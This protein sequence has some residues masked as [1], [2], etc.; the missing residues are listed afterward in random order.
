MKRRDFL[1]ASVVGGAAVATVSTKARRASAIP[2]F[3]DV[4]ADHASIMLP[5]ANQAT[6]ILECFMYGGVTPWEGFYCV[7]SYGQE[8]VSWHK[9]YPVD[10]L[11]AAKACSYAAPDLFTN[12]AKDSDGRDIFLSPF[13]QPLIARGD[14]TDRMRI[15]VNR[16]ALEPHE[17]AIPLTM[18]GATLGSP[19]MAALGAHIARY[20][21]DHDL[22]AK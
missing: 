7:P 1:K 13:L 22:E 21:V 20:F 8:G 19:S 17:A 12:F 9:A 14:I 2:L 4:P 16:H 18:A 11:N 6:S 10:F 15:V 5:K 3:G